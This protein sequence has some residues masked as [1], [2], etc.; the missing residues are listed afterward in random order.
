[1]VKKIFLYLICIFFFD[2]YATN[3]PD[4]ISTFVST[5]YEL[6]EKGCSQEEIIAIVAHN[7]DMKPVLQKLETYITELHN[8]KYPKETIISI[9]A[10]NKEFDG[11]YASMRFFMTV[12]ILYDI[13]KI[14]ITVT[15][16]IGIL[17][18]IR[19]FLKQYLTFTSWHE[20]FNWKKNIPQETPQEN[21]ENTSTVPPK[22]SPQEKSNDNDIFIPNV[23]QNPYSNKHNI[24]SSAYNEI[25]NAVKE[26]IKYAKNIGLESLIDNENIVSRIF[27]DS[28]RY[29][30]ILS[31]TID[32]QITYAKNIGFSG[33]LPK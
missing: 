12:N 32:E 3:A 25:Y 22:D 9:V 20:I 31:M 19:Y 21:S 5:L 4:T 18:Y 10:N 6:I 28:E 13:V 11:L 8:K 29:N 16:I 7:D 27:N 1:M 23:T 26:Q 24:K 17:Y 30:K 15:I 14:I 2:L 33:E